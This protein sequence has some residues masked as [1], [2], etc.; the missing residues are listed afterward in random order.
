MTDADIWGPEIRRQTAAW[1]LLSKCRVM[2]RKGIFSHPDQ[3]KEK[4]KEFLEVAP[5]LA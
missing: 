4:W 1:K 3:P 5:R 2:R